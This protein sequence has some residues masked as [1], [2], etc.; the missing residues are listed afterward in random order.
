[1]SVLCWAMV[2]LVVAGVAALFGFGGTA[3]GAAGTAEVLFVVFVGVCVVQFASGL[4]TY[5]AVT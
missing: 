5:K 2:F 1:M 3:E 4:T